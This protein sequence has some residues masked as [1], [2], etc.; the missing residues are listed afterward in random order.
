MFVNPMSPQMIL[1]ADGSMLLQ[2]AKAAAPAIR[3][4]NPRV[5]VHLD[6][7]TLHSKPTEY[8]KDFDIVIATELGF[9]D[10]VSRLCTG[11]WGNADWGSIWLTKPP[12]NGV[13]DST[14]PQPTVST[15]SSSRT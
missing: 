15:A 8:F 2:R 6:T 10:M 9:N 12:V 1:C 3:K 11:G 13:S 4:L 7:D 14:L 5:R